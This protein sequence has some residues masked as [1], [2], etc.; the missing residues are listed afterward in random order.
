[1]SHSGS[2]S[3]LTVVANVLIMYNSRK[4]NREISLHTKRHVSWQLSK[5][6]KNILLYLILGIELIFQSI[7][8]IS[9][10]RHIQKCI[11]LNNKI[12]C[13]MSLFHVF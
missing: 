6:V 11:T 3:N 12:V 10:M 9:R 2:F 1:M 8:W 5:W 7:L 13:N 4:I